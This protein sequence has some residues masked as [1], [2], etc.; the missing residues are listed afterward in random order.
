[1]ICAACNGAIWTHAEGV[2]VPPECDCGVVRVVRNSSIADD[3]RI[4]PFVNLYG[5]VVGEGATVGAFVEVQKGVSIGARAK[6]G[7]HSF[8]AART[9]IEAE[10]FIGHSV[11]TCNDRHPRAVAEDG[12]TLRKGEWKCEPVRVK[13]RA[14]VGSGAILLP[15]VTVGEGAVVGA[16]AVVTRDVPDEATVVGVPARVVGEDAP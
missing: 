4:G 12:H 3:A 11:V 10:A 5:C 16:G 8:L 2:P 1:M 6:I 13:R 15:G 14:A 7:S 9:I